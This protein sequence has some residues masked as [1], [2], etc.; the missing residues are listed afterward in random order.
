MGIREDSKAR[1]RQL[2]I[3]ETKSALFDKGY[4]K[5]STKDI[6]NRSDVSQGTIF[7]H[8][9]S[10]D[11]LLNNILTQLITDFM[12]DLKITCDVK[13]KRE[14]FLHDV[15][16][17]I[18]THESAL[19]IVYRDYPHLTEEIRKNLDSTE[20][21]LKSMFFDNIRNS[22]GKEISIVDSFVLIDAFI[23]QIK[24]YLLGKEPSSSSSIIKQSTG[25]LNK[26]YRY[27]FQ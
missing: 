19:S 22:K 18:S 16:S 4:I 20:S 5:L 27:L 8:F 14:D 1:T 11:N 13:S 17:V 26:L 7:L 6:S 21:N 10:K 9:Q 15:L 3:D 23:S 24:I 2:I 12:D 25:K